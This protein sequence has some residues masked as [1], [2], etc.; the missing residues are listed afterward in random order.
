[1]DLSDDLPGLPFEVLDLGCG[2]VFA[3]L[4]NGPNDVPKVVAFAKRS[5]KLFK[6]F[7]P[8]VNVDDVVSGRYK[9]FSESN[10][11]AKPSAASPSIV[12][13][14]P[15][16]DIVGVV[17]SALVGSEPGMA[18]SMRQAVL[19]DLSY[20]ASSYREDYMK[21]LAKD[22]G[23]F[24]AF[25]PFK[26]V[27]SDAH[28]LT[29]SAYRTFLT[30][31]GLPLYLPPTS[32]RGYTPRKRPAKG[33]QGTK[34]YVL[35]GDFLWNL[36]CDPTPIDLAFSTT[37]TT[38]VPKR[39]RV[40]T[41]DELYPEPTAVQGPLSASVLSSPA[42]SSTTIWESSSATLPPWSISQDSTLDC[43]EEM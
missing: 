29:G 42:S 39:G 20:L 15:G 13:P 3:Y 27:P 24:F 10:D 32:L 37:G 8:G 9:W 6:Q 31:Q 25:S 17:D 5:P 23:R 2:Q 19:A 35:G 14:A 43:N 1:M 4:P 30:N 28:K 11:T 12:T 21:R 36:A 16:T 22:R 34:I 40:Y 7:F 26:L 33:S 38:V 18:L 41:F